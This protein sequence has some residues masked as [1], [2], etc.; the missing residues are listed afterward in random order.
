[1]D[2]NISVGFLRKKE[3]IKLLGTSK[4]TFY[5]RINDGLFTKPISIG[6]RAVGFPSNEVRT[7]INHLIAGRSDCQIRELVIN[8][9]NDRALLAL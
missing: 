3:V 4:S 2:N 5:N 9:H 7:I 1:M 8:L 6:E